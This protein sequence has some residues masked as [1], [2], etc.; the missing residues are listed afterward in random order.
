MRSRQAD[1]VNTT[2]ILQQMRR[3]NAIYNTLHFEP[4]LYTSL[5]A[6]PSIGRWLGRQHVCPLLQEGGKNPLFMPAFP[7]NIH[8]AG[9]AADMRRACACHSGIPRIQAGN[10]L[11]ELDLV[12]ALAERQAVGAAVGR[13]NQ[14]FVHLFPQGVQRILRRTNQSHAS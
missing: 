14:L 4:G 11:P 13:R 9:S 3:S 7:N 1:S 8:L 5:V 10:I 12:L 6:R 2:I